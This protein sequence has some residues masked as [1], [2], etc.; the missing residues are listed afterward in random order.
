MVYERRHFSFHPTIFLRNVLLRFIFFGWKSRDRHTHSSLL[1][2]LSQRAS[3]ECVVGEGEK[4]IFPARHNLQ[5]FL[6]F[7]LIIILIFYDL[8]LGL[9]RHSNSEQAGAVGGE[10]TI[11][12]MGFG[13]FIFVHQI[14]RFNDA[15]RG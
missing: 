7:F 5:T 10:I 14:N 13:Q 12:H 15:W 8:H 2:N 9:A 6:F 3:V 11:T 4:M 1:A